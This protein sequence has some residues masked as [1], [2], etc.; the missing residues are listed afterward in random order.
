MEVTQFPIKINQTNLSNGGRQ[1]STSQTN[2]P[3]NS[4]DQIFARYNFSGRT[5]ASDRQSADSTIQNE[6]DME[7]SKLI[8]QTF[9]NEEEWLELDSILAAW[10]AGIQH[11]QYT[12]ETP[13]DSPNNSYSA[14]KTMIPA[15]SPMVDSLKQTTT[16]DN[17]GLDQWIQKVENTNPTETL[18][19]SQVMQRLEKVIGELQSQDKQNSIEV[20]VDIG[21]KIQLV[22]DESKTGNKF[23]GT[24]P[25]IRHSFK[26]P[27]FFDNKI[28]TDSINTIQNGKTGAF[29]LQN[30][31]ETKGNF[32]TNLTNLNTDER[33]KIKT[34]LVS[35]TKQVQHIYT[36][37]RDQLDNSYSG[38]ESQ[39]PE[40]S[41][42]LLNQH[43][44]VTSDYS[45]ALAHWLHRVEG[46]NQESTLDSSILIQR[47]AH[48]ISEFQLQDKQNT[49]EI[50]NNIEG[51]MQM[52]LDNVLTSPSSL[53]S[54][55]DPMVSNQEDLSLSQ[56]EAISF[57][58]K[59]SFT[60]AQTAKFREEGKFDPIPIHQQL[61]D[62]T[63]STGQ[64]VIINQQHESE[65]WNVSK[66]APSSP[67][68]S[69]SEFVPEV[70]GWIG[71]YLRSTNGQLGSTEA[72]FSLYPEHLGHIEIKITSQQGQISAQILA[73]TGLAKEALEGQLHQLKQALQQ[74]GL[75]VKNLEIVQQTPVSLDANQANLAFSQGGSHSSHE[76]RT[77]TTDQNVSKKQNESDETEIEK[78][79]MPVPYRG[80]VPRT[81]SQIDFTA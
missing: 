50:P 73:E 27:F 8:E 24:T 1:K 2:A 55:L 18:N 7:E 22:L 44:Q 74:Q 10:I 72:R 70:S 71:G 11:R 67:I 40:G 12:Q 64:T 80:A 42:A 53:F 57:Q 46:I 25:V 49:I 32:Q 58:E 81:V 51:K 6:S 17:K 33:W 78:E 41:A 9:P 36:I 43:H 19:P 30:V 61:E 52:I 26:N 65:G 3:V 63:K 68:L 75:L 66:S 34:S 60:S 77:F 69:V 48:F 23:V 56:D 21:D 47:L 31:S 59:Q 4:F 45:K 35:E 62:L 37:S 29:P 20:P 79:P 15:K 5:I 39:T 13:Q 54:N 76:Q 14:N 16:D 28:Q 38:S